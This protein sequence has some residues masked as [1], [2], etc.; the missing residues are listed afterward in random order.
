MMNESGDDGAFGSDD[1]SATAQLLPSD[2]SAA[3]IY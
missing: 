3:F 1:S 2:R